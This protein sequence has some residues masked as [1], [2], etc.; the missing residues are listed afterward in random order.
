VS[1]E[2][3]F[4]SRCSDHPSRVASALCSWSRSS[5]PRPS[6]HVLGALLRP[7]T[8]FPTGISVASDP[9]ATS[10]T[11]A[12]RTSW[13]TQAPVSIPHVL[14]FV[15][16]VL[17]QI[18][19]DPVPAR[20]S[21]A[22]PRCCEAAGSGRG[23]RARRW[24]HRSRSTIFVG[25]RR[26]WAGAETPHRGRRRAFCR[27]ED[28]A[29]WHPS[30]EVCRASAALENERQGEVN[31]DGLLENR[32]VLHVQIRAFRDHRARVPGHAVRSSLDPEVQHAAAM[33]R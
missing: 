16:L 10:S 20:A 32:G 18:D 22:A 30:Q 4:F 7:P 28:A 29:G 15:R 9:R 8:N 26:G 1:V 21:R 11:T 23:V 14:F 31:K 2:D 13:G 3:G 25:R 24:R 17:P 33:K 19:D 6:L 12:S 27:S 5:W